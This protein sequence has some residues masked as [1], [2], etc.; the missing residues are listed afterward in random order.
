MRR[1]AFT[2]Y[3]VSIGKGS[4]KSFPYKRKD[5]RL[6]VSMT[7]DNPAVGR[8]QA[9]VRFEAQRATR[10]DPRLFAGAVRVDAV[11]YLPRPKSIT[12]KAR[13]LPIVKPDVDKC[14]R[15][16]LD[17]CTGVLF[18]DDAAVVTLRVQK[19]YTSGPA[20]AVIAVSDVFPHSEQLPIE[21]RTAHA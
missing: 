2:V 6:A 20:K 13:P 4:M 1:V 17:A 19:V 15:L 14:A 10:D 12:L 9:A 3:G 8:W 5:G 21:T 18:A 16:I 7:A 11:F